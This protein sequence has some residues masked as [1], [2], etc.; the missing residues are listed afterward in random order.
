MTIA[1]EISKLQT[2]L[3]NSYTAIETKGGTLPEH[4]NF[5]NLSTAIE[6]ISSGGGEGTTLFVENFEDTNPPVGYVHLLN[7]NGNIE[8]STTETLSQGILPTIPIVTNQGK[9]F[10]IHSEYQYL[11]LYSYLKQSENDVGEWNYNQISFPRGYLPDYRHPV[12]NNKSTMTF[13]E[14]NSDNVYVVDYE[15]GP[16]LLYN[17]NYQPFL[18]CRFRNSDG[19]L[20]NEDGSLTY[21]TGFGG[22]RNSQI[23]VQDGK[24]DDV[25]IISKIG[26]V[27]FIHTQDFPNCT[28]E[29][30]TFTVT[31]GNLNLG[32]FGFEETGCYYAMIDNKT[33]KIFKYN[34]TSFEQVYTDSIYTYST[35]FVDQGQRLICYVNADRMPKKLLL[36]DTITDC[37]IPN[38][39]EIQADLLLN[40]YT[41]ENC[42]FVT[43]RAGNYASWSW[44]T[45]TYN[46]YQKICAYESDY[47][48][49]LFDSSTYNYTNLGGMSPVTS[50]TCYVTGETD[51][52]GKYEVA[53]GLR[54][55]KDVNVLSIFGGTIPDSVTMYGGVDNVVK[56]ELVGNGI[57]YYVD[58]YSGTPMK[59]VATKTGY[60]NAISYGS[61]VY[62]NGM[63]PYTGLN[64][65]YYQGAGYLMTVKNESGETPDYKVLKSNLG[66]MGTYGAGTGTYINYTKVGSPTVDALT[67]LASG[68]S[69]SSGLKLPQSMPNSITD[70]DII[71]KGNITSLSTHSVILAHSNTN[72][73]YIGIRK[74]G[75]FS[76]YDG[77][78]IE[79]IT[80]ISIGTEYWF[81]L[82]KDGNDYKGYIL[83][84]DGYTL[85]TLPSLSN[86]TQEFSTT[87]NIF[88]GYLFNIGYN[89]STTD[90]YFKG[91]IDL[92][93]CQIKIDNVVWW[94]PLSGNK[95]IVK[96]IGYGNFTKVGNPI[97]DIE[98]GVALGFGD[99]DYLQIKPFVTNGSPWEYY[100]KF[101]TGSSTSTQGIATC[102]G[103]SDGCSPFYIDN[104]NLM[105]FL[106]SNGSSWNIAGSEI[107][108][109]ISTN[110][111]YKMKAEFTGTE[112]NWYLWENNS[113]TLKK[114]ITSS[115]AIYDGLT[116]LLGN[117]RG[118]NNPFGGA[119]DL[120]ETYI[121][122]GGNTW[123]SP[124]GEYLTT[125]DGLL[126]DGVTDDGTAQTWNLFYNQST[127][128]YRLTTA[129]TLA[130]YVWCGEVALPAHTV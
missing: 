56:S 33:L 51:E 50:S 12:Y 92:S 17:R 96:A 124:L 55:N 123:W 13:I 22:T 43:N 76:M 9:A 67:G 26:K 49:R 10:F 111:T 41:A 2:N 81:R 61:K 29:D 113:W 60:Y 98:T 65:S 82:I 106:S 130:D 71:F 83:V 95:Y 129:D 79:G 44:R 107:I 6:S 24:A 54:I 93:G 36:D 126:P 97:V 87:S 27:S 15:H 38:Y 78:W 42:S 117:N 91:S 35:P 66:C 11:R 77:S 128:Q 31:S 90:E 101:T 84:D 116:M 72:E 19:Y 8:G 102:V 14:L 25:I 85:N 16:K 21:N 86:W 59:I 99:S 34:G 112:Y 105:A 68:F 118:Q 115:L 20:T 1:S 127:N 100:I 32:V 104:G 28:Q 75:K 52:D 53:T 110:T 18:Y 103:S 30:F 57:Q 48:W 74:T 45:G 62:L 125:A 89:Y 37:Y 114:T 3:E 73:K 108:M 23:L 4:Q 121:T 120:S 46:N 63:T 122:I 5:D 69:T 39:D 94:S 88:D 109:S 80:N 7:M 70:L 47:K 119:I 58:V 64:M 40:T